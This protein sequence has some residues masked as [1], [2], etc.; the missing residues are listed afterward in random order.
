MFAAVGGFRYTDIAGGDPYWTNV[1]FLQN[2]DYPPVLVQD[3]STDNNIF[4]TI[5]PTV[6]SVRTPFT[7]SG[8][9]IFL[10]GS[11][12]YLTSNQN[13]SY[14]FGTGNFTV[15]AWVYVTNFTVNFGG[16]MP[17]ISWGDGSWKVFRVRPTA[18]NFQTNVPSNLD[19]NAN[20]PS[21]MVINTW[22]HV[23]LVRSNTTTV[24]AYLNG[25][26]G[27]ALTINA[28]ATFGYITELF[29]VGLKQGDP[30]YWYGY[31][32]NLRIT[33]SAV[34][35]SNFTPATSPLSPI[36]NTTLML[37]FSN[38]GIGKNNIAVDESIN[39][40]VVTSNGTVQY[41]GIS[42]YGV[43]YPGSLRLSSNGYMTVPNST[44]I[45]YGTG[46]FTMECW[47]RF[48]SVATESYIIDQRISTANVVIPT[49]YMDAG[50]L[51]NFYV[52]GAN[53]IT[54]TT[55]LTTGVW[56]H[57]AVSRNSGST[58]MYLNGVQEGS[59]Y[60]DSNNY[61]TSRAVIGSR[62][63]TVGL[64]LSGYVNNVRLS[65]GIGYYP[66]NFTPPTTPLTPDVTYT[67]LMIS[68]DNGAFYST[69]SN[70]VSPTT[71]TNTA[72]STN[73]GISPENAVNKFGT[74]SLFY[75]GS[76]FQTV[77][78]NTDLRFGT[79]AFTIEGWIYIS[80]PLTAYGV[81]NKGTSTTGW[82]LQ[83][84]TSTRFTWY[85]G[86]SIIK[87]SSVFSTGA[88]TYFTITRDGSSNLYMFVNGTLQGSSVTDSTDY[89]QTNNMI[90]GA[91]RSGASALGSAYTDEI[92]I[93]YG[94]CRYTSSFTPPTSAFPTSS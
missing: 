33:K 88:W 46:D 83:I 5:G 3:T 12:G 1:S 8:G 20:W 10:S 60:A 4:R 32:S 85:S 54:G 44:A 23:A 74:N 49:I 43:S 41:S 58:K 72:P 82:S 16:Y 76:A 19:Y 7:G 61:V 17:L 15:E 71:I 69:T 30:G 62:G 42:P 65:K 52:S 21:T 27:S 9:S 81:I 55:I 38:T 45:S 80:L 53:Q 18:F 31:I 78:D 93:T 68:C 2:N 75:R 92:R 67:G 24:T 91:D 77:I 39:S 22:Y 36:T 11:A 14:D 64:Y 57:I 6:P 56:Y 13:T 50:K 29:H 90:I 47:V 37:N 79:G 48:D 59:T 63:A 26:A 84:D 34:Y 73:A 40:L 70:N 86:S 66:N 51:L 94:V 89:N 35:T 87:T 25:V 28:S